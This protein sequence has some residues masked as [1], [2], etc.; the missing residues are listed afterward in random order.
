[1]R[2]VG[3][4][5]GTPESNA[6]WAAS[7]DYL[8][9]LWSDEERVLANHYGVLSF[10]DD[11]PLRHAYLLDEEGRAVLFYEGAV[12]LG[13]DPHDVLEDAE[14]WVAGTD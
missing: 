7:L 13:A 11:Q 5:F 10:A 1:V 8:Y 4:G 12:S 3:A 2:I 6:G 14:L 9:E